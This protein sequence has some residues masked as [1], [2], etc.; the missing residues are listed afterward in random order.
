M[1]LAALSRVVRTI[2]RH[3]HTCAHHDGSTLAVRRVTG[4]SILNTLGIG[5]ERSADA[6]RR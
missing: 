6:I 5:F 4:W 2:P 1:Q 3:G